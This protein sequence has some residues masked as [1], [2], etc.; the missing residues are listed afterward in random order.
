MSTPVELPLSQVLPGSSSDHAGALGVGDGSPPGDVPQLETPPKRRRLS[1]KRPAAALW[2]AAELL[3]QPGHEVEGE[4][5]GAEAAEAAGHSESL[6]PPSVEG[7]DATLSRCEYK[8]FHGKFWR[9]YAKREGLQHP[10]APLKCKPLRSLGVLQ[11][12]QMIEAWAKEDASCPEDFKTRVLMRFQVASQ[13]PEV[14]S[15][16]LKGNGWLFT[17]NGDWGLLPLS[18]VDGEWLEIPDLCDKL[19]DHPAVIA[20]RDKFVER[21]EFWTDKLNLK[22]IAYCIELSVGSY[23]E[24]K[25]LAQESFAQGQPSSG[26]R[27]ESLSPP[28][29]SCGAPQEQ[30]ARPLRLHIHAWL[31]ATRMHTIK[32]YQKVFEFDDSAP[33]VSSLAAAAGGR[34]QAS[35]NQG[36]YYVQCP[37]IGQVL[38]GG[39]IEPFRDYLVNANWVSHM[40][41]LGKLSMENAREQIVKTGTNVPRMLENLERVRAEREVDRLKNHVANVHEQLALVT[42]PMRTIPLVETWLGSYASVLF[43]YR[44]LVLDGPSQMGKT[45]FCRSLSPNRDCFLEV[46]CAGKLDPDLREF[47]ALQHDT[48]LFDEASAKMVLKHKKLFQASASWVTMSSSTTNMY[49][50]K[51]WTHQVKMIIA[52]N[53]WN[54]ELQTLQVADADWLRSNSFY[55]A[56][57]SPLW[58]QEPQP[59][60][61]SRP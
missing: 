37:K 33:M 13:R 56:V 41:Q 45:V 59:G 31:K 32:N 52:S 5:K 38:M 61:A 36:A 11:R 29:E 16:I 21:C 22:D 12:F 17:W 23:K 28:T 8:I 25:A 49:S 27:S 42:R 58:V 6:S 60:G 43:R 1:S 7:V 30:D 10:D 44:F 35:G 51:I 40:V 39:N 2:M 24:A 14:S 3:Q 55:V 57:T 48:L 26:D 50:Y 53:R 47:R 15:G 18:V 34:K 9:W 19:K 4:K 20:M 46:D 54:V